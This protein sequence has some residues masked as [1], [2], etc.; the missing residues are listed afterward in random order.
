[1]G[2]AYAVVEDG[3]V[4]LRNLHIPI[5]RRPPSTITIPS[6]RRKLLRIGRRSKG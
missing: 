5:T 6:A 4:W 1:M 2:D 3:E